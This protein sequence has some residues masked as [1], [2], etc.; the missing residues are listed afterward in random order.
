MLV[1]YLAFV[2]MRD[3]M[4]N[5]GLEAPGRVV[6]KQD[7]TSSFPYSPSA[8]SSSSSSSSSASFSSCARSCEHSPSDSA[9]GLVSKIWYR[10]PFDDQNC[11][12]R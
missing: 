10:I 4:L 1:S 3:T 5:I 6:E 2:V 8:S 12:F 11:P 7:S 9:S